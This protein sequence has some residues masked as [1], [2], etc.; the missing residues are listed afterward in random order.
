[1]ACPL[2][3]SL[4]LTVLEQGLL[5][6]SFY[7]VFSCANGEFDIKYAFAF[8]TTSEHRLYQITEQEMILQY[9][10]CFTAIVGSNF[11]WYHKMNCDL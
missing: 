4:R 11:V 1:M 10:A 5:M 7:S 2:P 8:R 9:S 3:C 6:H